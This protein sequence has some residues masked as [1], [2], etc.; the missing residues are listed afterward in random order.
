MNEFPNCYLAQTW[1]ELRC[2]GWMS[3]ANAS[4]ATSAISQWVPPASIVGVD[5]AGS[6]EHVKY[7]NDEQVNELLAAV[8]KP[9]SMGT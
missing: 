7:F 1:K 8:C 6:W 3:P 2:F 5:P 4:L 9:H